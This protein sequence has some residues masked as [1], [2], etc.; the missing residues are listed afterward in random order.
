MVCRGGLAQPASHFPDETL[1]DAGNVAG[2]DDA[3]ERVTTNA[4]G[5]S[6]RLP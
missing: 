5:A 2:L 3:H 6:G 1:R 4:G